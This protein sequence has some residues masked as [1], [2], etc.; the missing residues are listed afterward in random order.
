MIASIRGEVLDVALDHVVIEAC[1][2]GYKRQRDAVDA[3]HRGAEP[4]PGWS[5]R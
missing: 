1:G 2:V 5:P 3:V 4:R